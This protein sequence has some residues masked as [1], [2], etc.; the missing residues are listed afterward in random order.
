MY[1]LKPTVASSAVGVG[2]IPLRKSHTTI[3]HVMDVDDD[4]RSRSRSGDRGS[5]CYR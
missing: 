3:R 1:I 4:L 5:R 2:G